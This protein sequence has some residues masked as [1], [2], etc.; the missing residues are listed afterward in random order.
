MKKILLMGSGAR[1]HAIARAIKR[2]N[3]LTDLYCF[4]STINPGIKGLCEDYYT[5]NLC[6]FEAIKTCLGPE[7][8]DFVIIGPEAPLAAG[9]ADRF[10]ENNIPVIGPKAVLAQIEASKGFTRNLWVEHGI[11]GSPAYSVFHSM[12][13]VKDFLHAWKN[14]YVIKADGLM[15]GKGV[16]VFGEHLHHDSEA[17]V[18]CESLLSRGL[19]F[20]MEEKLE[21]EEFSLI[22]FSDGTHLVHCPLVQD[23]KRAFVGDVGPNTGGMGSYSDADHG[24]PFISASEIAIAQSM[25]E[26]TIVALHEKYGERYIGFL[27]GGFMAT[28]SGV[29]LIEYNARLGDPEAMNILSIL[30]ADFVELCMNMIEGTLAAY[31]IAFSKQ[32]TVCKYAVPLGYPD[33]PVTGERIDISM[34]KNHDHCYLAAVDETPEG[35][36]ETGSRTVAVVGIADSL[37]EAEKMAEAEINRVKGPLFHRE[38]IGTTALIKKRIAHMKAVHG[39]VV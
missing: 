3:H 36:I 27:Y 28:Q 4:G 21:G 14:Q 38:D 30:E 39:V 18:F 16:K 17:I 6:D 9:I 13:G 11:K 26:K 10:W 34:V 12:D 20:V 15:G 29:K 5:G 31:P 1:E 24:L 35:L 23:H 19:S 37:C 8:I 22:S 25:N 2:S 32:A 33:H 7:R